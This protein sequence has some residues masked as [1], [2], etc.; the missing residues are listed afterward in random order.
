M[1]S[2]KGNDMKQRTQSISES[3]HQV[4]NIVLQLREISCDLR[5]CDVLTDQLDRAA[6]QLRRFRLAV[7]AVEEA[8][9]ATRLREPV[10][11]D[12]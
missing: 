5:D 7:Q 12:N 10:G 11:L 9:R 4:A 3:L 2:E 8:N 6:D 1:Q